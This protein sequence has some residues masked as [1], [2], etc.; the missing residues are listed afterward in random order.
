MIIVKQ[1]KDIVNFSRVSEIKIVDYEA[2]KESLE[3]KLGD[4]F[5]SALIA[6]VGIDDTKLSG[7]GIYAYFEKDNWSVLGEYKTEER[8]K[9]VLQEIAQ[10][11][12]SYLKLEGGPAIL[13]GQID[14][15][16]N[17]FNIPKVYEM[18]ED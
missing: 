18:P 16:P 3:N 2:Q 12:S 7:Y 6:N 5:V 10:K 11:F 17:I 8:A 15:Q 4:I 1:N 9:E 13:Q 14:I